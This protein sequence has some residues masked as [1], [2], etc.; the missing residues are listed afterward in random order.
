MGDPAQPTGV[1][2]RQSALSL[3]AN[4]LAGSLQSS[5]YAQVQPHLGSPAQHLQPAST[6]GPGLSH[7]LL[8]HLFDEFV[9]RSEV[10]G[11]GALQQAGQHLRRETEGS[12]RDG[13]AWA[14]SLVLAPPFLAVGYVT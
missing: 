9:G 13:R 1:P 4:P 5:L 2:Q 3:W 11:V 6:L 10:L 8:H 14:L 7:H 12:D